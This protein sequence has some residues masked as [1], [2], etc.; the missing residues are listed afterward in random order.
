MNKQSKK[1]Q[2]SQED[3]NRLRGQDLVVDFLVRERIPV[4]RKNYL[5]ANYGDPDYDKTED[6]GGELEAELPEFLQEE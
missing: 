1:S 6:W 3:L 5:F 4:T 2:P